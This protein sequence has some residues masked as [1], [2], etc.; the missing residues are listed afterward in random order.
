MNDKNLD[1]LNDQLKYTGFGDDNRSALKA[2]MQPL[3]SDFVLTHETQFGLEKATA[4]LYFRRPAES[5]MYFFN[6][7]D[8]SIK[9]M[10]G[11]ESLKQTFY[12]HNRKDNISLKEAYNLLSG[13][14]VYKTLSNK[15]GQPFHAWLQM[16][17][18]ER[19]K[20]GNF[21]L[22][23]FHQNYGFDLQ[24]VI[25]QL[26]IKELASSKEKEGLLKSLERGN[27]QAVTL[28]R[29]GEE[30]KFY[31][32][33]APKFK[34]VNIYTGNMERINLQALMGKETP[35]QTTNVAVAKAQQTM[36]QEPADIQNASVKKG[37]RK[38]QSL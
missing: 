29:N 6:K 3:P 1:Y 31:I 15:E 11:D 13:R 14:A 38:R 5:D 37:K 30:Q 8:L 2:Q 27:R 33:A 28:S 23:Q 18:K 35:K 10:D 36:K 32:E 7:Y 22:K 9:K 24:K 4:S 16:D 25:E 19:D 12:I 20:N 17:F 34:S 26:P 21:Q